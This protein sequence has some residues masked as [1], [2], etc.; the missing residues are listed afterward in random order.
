[1]LEWAELSGPTASAAKRRQSECDPERRMERKSFK[2]TRARTQS[3]RE[4]RVQGGR[5]KR[6]GHVDRQA[7]PGASLHGGRQH[8]GRQPLK[9]GGR[10]GG[11]E[12]RMQEVGCLRERR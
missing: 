1:M 3:S 5:E 6:Q 4:G 10:A 2:E 9:Q 7:C 8:V 12:G 11:S